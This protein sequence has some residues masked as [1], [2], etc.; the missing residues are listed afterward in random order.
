VAVVMGSKREVERATAHHAAGAAN[1]DL[2]R[3]G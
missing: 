3:T 1:T 2:Q